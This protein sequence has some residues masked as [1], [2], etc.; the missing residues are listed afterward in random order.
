MTRKT[1]NK[2]KYSPLGMTSTK[3]EETIWA[4]DEPINNSHVLP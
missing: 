3:L 1:N 2:Y 4:L